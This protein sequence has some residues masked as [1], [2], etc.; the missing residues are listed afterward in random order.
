MK[1]LEEIKAAAAE[2]SP[3]EQFELFRWCTQSDAFKARQLEA[4]KREVARGIHD[5][6]EGKYTS[7]QSEELT[8]LKDEIARSGRERQER[9]SRKQH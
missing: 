5:L 9:V 8:V 3:D 6:E 1:T 7:Y 4:L 2:L